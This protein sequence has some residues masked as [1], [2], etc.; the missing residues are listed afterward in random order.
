M[1]L[2]SIPLYFA[3]FV[4]TFM[5][6]CAIGATVQ[7]RKAFRDVGLGLFGSLKVFTFV[8]VWQGLSLMA[9]IVQLPL[10]LVGKDTSV[11]S[12]TVLE[13][14]IATCCF[15]VLN[16][17]CVVNNKD[18][19]PKPGTPPCVYVMNHQSTLDVCSSYFL[20]RQM[21]WVAKK[22]VA[23]L[24]GVGQILVLSKHILLDR[25]GRASILQVRTKSDD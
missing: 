20:A 8:F 13:Y 24:P 14:Y 1:E 9:A 5:L 22:S 18:K 16:G 2:S 15:Q 12:N 10:V 11:F 6:V 23:V 3:Y 19:I 17:P 21:C 4:I 7:E 25:K